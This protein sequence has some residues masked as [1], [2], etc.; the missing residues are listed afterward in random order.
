MA[1]ESRSQGH[2]TLGWRCT[3]RFEQYPSCAR[4]SP[5]NRG[6]DDFKKSRSAERPPVWICGR[7]LA[8]VKHVGAGSCQIGSTEGIRTC[9]AAHGGSV[10]WQSHGCPHRRSRRQAK[11][12]RSLRNLSSTGR[13]RRCEARYGFRGV[14][15]GEALHP[16][17]A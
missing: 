3:P 5:G 16:G 1:T 15:V 7:D 14:R 13:C 2:D 4:R 9:F 6:V 8:D 11:V 10:S 12:S 17:P